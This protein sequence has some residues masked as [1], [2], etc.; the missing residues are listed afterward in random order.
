MRARWRDIFPV[1]API[2]SAEQLTTS[3]APASSG[4]HH[5]YGTNRQRQTRTKSG[6]RAWRQG[7]HGSE[8]QKPRLR[9]G[10]WRDGLPRHTSGRS[11]DP[12]TAFTADQEKYTEDGTETKNA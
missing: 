2:G 1:G 4:I 3:P 9:G 7:G 6:G 12:G 8:R 5:L 10:A 11:G